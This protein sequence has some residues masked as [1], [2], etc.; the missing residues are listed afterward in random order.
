MINKVNSVLLAG[1]W[2]RSQHAPTARALGFIPFQVNVAY[3]APLKA[4][5]IIATMCVF[6]RSVFATSVSA[7]YH[8]QIMSKDASGAFAKSCVMNH[9]HCIYPKARFIWGSSPAR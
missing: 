4:L 2:P 7:N 1:V 8:G 6:S 3:L 9:Y 5:Q